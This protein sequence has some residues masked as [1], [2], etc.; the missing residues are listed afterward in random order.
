MRENPPS[1]SEPRWTRGLC[2]WIWD[3]AL[4][5]AALASSIMAAYAFFALTGSDPLDFMVLA[6]AVGGQI[7]A[8]ASFRVMRDDAKSE[9]QVALESQADG[10]VSPQ[11]ISTLGPVGV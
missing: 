8:A 10:N 7:S 9:R 1:K 3:N 5:I 6:L 4:W 11:T 2:E